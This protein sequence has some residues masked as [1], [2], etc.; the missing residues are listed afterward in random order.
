MI[1]NACFFLALLIVSW[2]SPIHAEGGCPPGQYPQQGQGWQTCVPIPGYEDA[3]QTSQPQPAWQDRW[4]AIAA[5][6]KKGILG[7]AD[8]KLTKEAAIQT[9]IDDCKSKGGSDCRMRTWYGNSCGAM[10][11][12]EKGF[13]V[14]TGVTKEDAIKKGIQTCQSDGDSACASYYS[15]CS[16]PIR[17]Q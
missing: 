3:Q 14:A 17:V 4:G 8:A 13:A 9:A 1:R 11:V 15:S 2:V 7:T 12:G 5:D 10:A 16:L 6:G